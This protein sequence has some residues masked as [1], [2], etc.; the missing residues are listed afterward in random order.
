[1]KQ[2]SAPTSWV[3]GTH[4]SRAVYYRSDNCI[5]AAWSEHFWKPISPFAGKKI[6]KP[7]QQDKGPVFI[8]SAPSLDAYSKEPITPSEIIHHE[9][10][11]PE[12]NEDFSF[13]F[14]SAL[15]DTSRVC[16][17][18]LNTTDT[19]DFFSTSS[20]DGQTSVLPEAGTVLPEVGTILLETETVLPEM[21]TAGSSHGSS[22]TVSDCTVSDSFSKNSPR[23]SLSANNIFKKQEGSRNCPTKALLF[24]RS[25]SLCSL[26]G[27]PGCSPA[28]MSPK[29]SPY[30]SQA[31]SP[32]YS[33]ISTDNSASS[34]NHMTEVS[35]GSMVRRYMTR[36]LSW[37]DHLSNANGNERAVLS[38]EN[39]MIDLSQLFLGERFASGTYSRIY[40]GMYRESPVAVKVIR[41]PDEDGF[42]ADRLE[43]SFMQEVTILSCL[44][45][46]NVIKFIAACKK[47]PVLCVITEYLPGGSIRAFLHKR[48]GKVLPI[49]QVLRMA[50]DVTY[51]MEYLHMK[52][53]VHRDL[54]SENLVLGDDGCV[55]ILDFGT[56]CFESECNSCGDNL[57]TYRW[58]APEMLSQKPYTRKV[59]IYSFGIV[60][61]ELLTAHLPYE[62]MGAVQAAFCVINKNTRPP[63]PEDCPSLL[64]DLMC[65]CWSTEPEERPEFWEILR[66][67]NMCMQ[68]SSNN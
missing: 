22:C 27:S 1:M 51:G 4:F 68:D 41:Q 13:S 45:H 10:P 30:N 42:L 20:R 14:P 7:K 40:H 56:S 58:M 66:V 39:W 62:D 59:D 43:K 23:R 32:R 54:K 63:I 25:S 55:K 31:N 5:D 67:L 28:S 36:A 29:D 21:E 38:A 11:A 47:P 8:S 19:L 35:R 61:W 53:V 50:L 64:K 57:G 48:E 15:S 52:G 46:Q 12:A 17:S 65:H 49:P 37:S 44:Q 3:L 2:E 33:K 9:G 34:S 24:E 6:V 60:L 16:D 18:S 26:K